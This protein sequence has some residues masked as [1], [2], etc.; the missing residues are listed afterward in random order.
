MGPYD[1]GRFTTA[2]ASPVGTRE[3]LSE[4]VGAM[5]GDFRSSGGDEWENRTLEDFLDAL[6]ACVGARLVT[7]PAEAQEQP[8]WRA[9]AE[10]LRAAT[11]YE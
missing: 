7:E 10:I 6:E 1:T 11:G 3:G 4:F 5:L 9:F 2:D 8:S